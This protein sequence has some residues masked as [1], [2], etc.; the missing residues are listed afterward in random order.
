MSGAG[1]GVM[2]ASWLTRRF[3]SCYMLLKYH[4]GTSISPRE[5]N[6]KEEC[7]MLIHSL[8][9]VKMMMAASHKSW[10]YAQIHS[11]LQKSQMQFF[12]FVIGVLHLCETHWLEVVF[13]P[14]HLSKQPQWLIS[15]MVVTSVC[16]S[17]CLPIWPHNALVFTCKHIYGFRNAVD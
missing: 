9:T 13:K 17:R 12:D 16:N 8:M 6:G 3:C 1:E 10:N 14:I 11:E 5:I 2:G 15:Y 7:F 4:L